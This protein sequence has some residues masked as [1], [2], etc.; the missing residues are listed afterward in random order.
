MTAVH[1]P[2]R[3]LVLVGDGKRALF[4][5][6]RGTPRQVELVVER[7]M[8]HEDLRSRDIGSDRP[9]R[10]HGA[11]GVSRSAIEETDWHQQSESR[12]AADV[13]ATLYD[14]GHA[15]QFEELV[16]VA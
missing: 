12:F 13:A 11:D 9:G 15:H 7:E 6:N 16:V 2:A 4:L 3:A 14:M 10:K 1:I 5:R 8:G